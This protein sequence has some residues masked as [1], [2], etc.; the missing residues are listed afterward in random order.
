MDLNE[1]VSRVGVHYDILSKQLAEK[2]LALKQFDEQIQ[3]HK[4]ST[5]I[6]KLWLNNMMN[7]SLNAIEPIVTSGISSV[8]DDQSIKFKIDRLMKNNRLIFK[9]NI[10]ND[11]VSGDPMKSFGGGV[12][13][14]A[15]FVLRVVIMSK[16][17]NGGLLLLDE[18]LNALANKY[19]DNASE[20][21]RKLSQETGINILMVTH[22]DKFIDGSDVSYSCDKDD[23][24]II[25]K[26]L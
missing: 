14:V 7:E 13:M 6:F 9:F 22:N 16:I 11:G 26:V 21:M 10:E 17:G 12:V 3:L 1:A 4:K 5:E 19:I 8:I 24:L 20:L 2:K 25:S 15:S 23:A 18:S